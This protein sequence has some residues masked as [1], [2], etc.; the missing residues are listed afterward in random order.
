MAGYH[1]GSSL[2]LIDAIVCFA[3]STR[4]YFSFYES[5][6]ARFAFEEAIWLLQWVQEP[7]ES[8]AMR[9]GKKWRS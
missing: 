4:N 2:A 3:D 9:D 6:F 8:C 1:P 7:P 5:G